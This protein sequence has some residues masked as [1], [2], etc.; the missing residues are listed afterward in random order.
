MSTLDALA[1]LLASG[2]LT[3]KTLADGTGVILDVESLQV[4]TLNETG[5][6]LVEALTEGAASVDELADRLTDEFDVDRA[7]A[8]A[9]VEVFVGGLEGCFGRDRASG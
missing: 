6:F 4:F 3:Q 7:T 8:R 9:D 2:E 1:G 5:M